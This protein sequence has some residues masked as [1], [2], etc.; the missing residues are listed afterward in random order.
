MS[1]NIENI[2]NIF[3]FEESKF[4]ILKKQLFA[5]NLDDMVENV[6]EFMDI[7]EENGF[8]D[9]FCKVLRL[10]MLELSTNGIVHGNKNS[11]NKE[12]AML[13]NIDKENKKIIFISAD[14]GNGFDPNSLPDP[15]KTK[16]IFRTSGRGIFIVKHYVSDYKYYDNG[17]TIKI[18]LE[19]ENLKTKS[20]QLKRPA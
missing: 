11:T 9:N 20:N 1:I 6:F 14:E 18:I 15:R 4:S 16:N 8:S 7:A 19:E 17:K 10:I 13:L 3:N 5:N 2:Q 12:I